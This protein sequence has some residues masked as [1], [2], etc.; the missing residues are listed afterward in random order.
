VNQTAYTNSGYVN[1]TGT[2]PTAGVI[3]LNILGAAQAGDFQSAGGFADQIFAGIP[4]NLT[5]NANTNNDFACEILAYVEFPTNGAYTLGV[6]SDDGFRLIRDWTP[7]TGIG[8]LTVNSPAGL[9]GRKPTVLNG[10][11]GGNTPYIS[12]PL[13]NTITGN[14]VL[15]GGIG[16]GSTTNGEG[17]L[18]SNPGQLT[19]NIA[20]M[21]RSAS[22]G[23]AQQVANAQAAGAIAVVF[24]QNRPATE[25]PFPQEP[26]VSPYAAIPAVEIEQADGNAIVAA[27][28][29][30]AVVNATLTPMDYAVNPPPAN[31]VL[32]QDDQGKGATDVQFPVFVQQAG[33]YPLRLTYWQGNGGGNCEFF[34]V[35]GPNRVL[36]NNRTSTLGPGPGGSGLRAWYA[37]AA[38]AVSVSLLNGNVVLTFN[39]ILQSATDVNGPYA[40]VVGATSPYTITPTQPQQFFRARMS[41]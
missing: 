15:A 27:L 3:N 18:I 36:I 1:L 22:C 24:I 2:G 41:N 8:T 25:G 35:T 9:A 30:S 10:S 29:G 32:G 23:Y 21:Y 6:A 4:G 20:V 11:S 33:I 12:L 19:G 39:G 16:F 26:A 13:T 5:A 34:T 28:A 37:L 17:C 40:D 31:P 14:L 7:P 38:P